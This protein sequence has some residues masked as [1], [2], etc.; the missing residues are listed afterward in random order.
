[1]MLPE[2]L[3]APYQLASQWR[4]NRA[5][6]HALL[7]TGTNGVGQHFFAE[8]LA[9]LLLCE[10][11]AKAPCGVCHSCELAKA[12]THPD[13]L[14]LD[15]S[16]GTIKVDAVRQVVSKVSNKPQLGHTKVVLIY[17]AHNMNIN[18]ANA[19]LK[20]LEEPPSSTYFLLTSNTSRSLMPTIISR[21]QRL[22]LANPT[23]EQTIH[24]LQ[25]E[26]KQGAG[27]LL[28]FSQ[29]P[30]RL[31]QLAE[32]SSAEMMQSLPADLSRWLGGEIRSDELVASVNNERL[33]DFVDGVSALIHI[34]LNYSVTGSCPKDVKNTVENLLKHYDLYRLMTISSN[35]TQLKADLDKTHLNPTIQLIGEL[36]SW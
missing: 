29:S 10:N 14:T 28:W 21:C 17:D 13:W 18:A 11:I 20:A 33:R 12:E 4:H 6:H 30:F 35:L 1:M 24:W 34:A 25:Q 15:G 16:Q 3:E 22:T 36:N 19:I 2:W 32:S 8:R 31:L 27:E 26:G 5:F 9:K 23:T 7:L